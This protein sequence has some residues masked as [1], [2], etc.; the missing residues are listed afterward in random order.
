[1][2]DIVYLDNNA[3]TKIDPRVLEAMMPY[4]TDEYAN[5]A[6]KH[7]FGTTVNE[8]VKKAR[9]SVSELIGAETNEIIFTAGAT[10]AIN[11]AIKG[12]AEYYINK[13][14][15]IITVETEHRAVLDVCKYLETKGFEIDY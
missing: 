11:L 7:K 15:H 4:L 5:A 8:A 3:T 2:N 9:R 6:S 1:M 10:E 14:N 13:G 12:V